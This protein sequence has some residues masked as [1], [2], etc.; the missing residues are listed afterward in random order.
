MHVGGPASGGNAER[1]RGGGE[2]SNTCVLLGRQWS[3]MG[4][5]WSEIVANS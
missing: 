5:S 4:R 3:A 2:V 1:G